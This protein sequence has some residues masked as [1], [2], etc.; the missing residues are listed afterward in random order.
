MSTNLINAKVTVP[1]TPTSRTFGEHF[2][3]QVNVRDFGAKGDGVTDDTAAIQAAVT[4]ACNNGLVLM[5][6]PANVGQFYNISDRILIPPYTS[7]WAI[8]GA[9]HRVNIKQT[10]N[11]KPFLHFDS[12][13]T[14]G[15]GLTNGGFDVRNFAVYWTTNQVIANTHSA[16]IEFN[17]GGYADFMI[18]NIENVNGCRCITHQFPGQTALRQ[19]NAWGCL[20][21]HIYNGFAASGA[22]LYLRSNPAEGLPNINIQHVYSAQNAAG[23]ELIHIAGGTQIVIQNVEQNFGSYTPGLVCWAGTGMVH[24]IGWRVEVFDWLDGGGA[25]AYFNL[26]GGGGGIP[27]FHIQGFETR[28]AHINMT[29]PKYVVE[30]AGCRI[31]FDGFQDAAPTIVAGTLYL[32]K[33]D[34]A[35]DI[36][37]V[38]I[39]S[40]ESTNI[41][42]CDPTNAFNSGITFTGGTR[43]MSF[44]KNTLTTSMTNVINDAASNI[45]GTPVVQ[46]GWIWALRV[47]LDVAVSAGTATFNIFKN[48]TVLDTGSFAVIMTSGTQAVIYNGWLKNANHITYKVLPGDVLDVRVTTTGTL[49]GPVNAKAEVVIASI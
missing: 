21:R 25:Q 1:S 28:F 19:L 11:N 20:Y 35:L 6:P 2:S 39:S 37:E 49:A 46:M 23:E 33:L 5:F 15:S 43:E 18:E 8:R 3:D 27:E 12:F 7:N 14:S 17:D 44:Y 41:K 45:K 32:V 47:Q 26:A 10:V 9:T 40:I 31:V 36:M 13:T 34:S 30:G 38:G 24:I 22:A 42:F 16:V 48:G 4:Y 29:A